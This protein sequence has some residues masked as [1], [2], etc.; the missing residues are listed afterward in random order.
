MGEISVENNYASSQL[1]HF[2]IKRLKVASQIISFKIKI[3]LERKK[4]NQT[5]SHPFEGGK[6]RKELHKE[7]EVETIKNENAHKMK[8]QTTVSS[9]SP[10]EKRASTQRREKQSFLMHECSFW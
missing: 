7:M 2:S 5:R 4:V 3:F 1:A 10:K 8:F 6:R 9:N